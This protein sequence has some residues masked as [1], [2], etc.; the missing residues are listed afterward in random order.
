MRQNP[1]RPKHS[2]SGLLTI[3]ILANTAFAGNAPLDGTSQAFLESHC[4]TCHGET[5]Q[6]GKLRLDTLS[7]D[8]SD[9]QIAEKWNEVAFRLNA[10]EMTPEEEPNQPT[11]EAIGPEDIA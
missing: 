10:G 1:S 7:T 8:F 5:K 3:V 11:A 4:F 2:A 9:P 6:K